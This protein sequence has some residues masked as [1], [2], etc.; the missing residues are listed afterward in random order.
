MTSSPQEGMMAMGDLH[1][2]AE[3]ATVAIAGDAA[4]A[5]AACAA[6]AAIKMT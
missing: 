3:K 4:A 6:A 5:C 1:H 2:V